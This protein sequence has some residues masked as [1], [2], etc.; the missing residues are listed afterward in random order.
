MSFINFKIQILLIVGML[1]I[2]S[3]T[4]LGKGSR[5]LG[6]SSFILESP[7]QAYQTE[8]TRVETGFSYFSSATY[9]LY[10]QNSPLDSRLMRADNLNIGFGYQFSGF[11]RANDLPLVIGIKAQGLSG[12]GSNSFEYPVTA[13]TSAAAGSASSTDT[14]TTTVAAAEINGYS[15]KKSDT[16][17][18]PSLTYI[19]FDSIAIGLAANSHSVI[20]TSSSYSTATHSVSVA[21]FGVVYFNDII[22]TGVSYRGANKGL[23]ANGMTNV[24]EPGALTL[25]N[26][27]F[28]SANVIGGFALEMTSN[29]AGD[30][31]EKNGLSASISAE[32]QI[33]LLHLEEKFT[34]L[35]AFHENNGDMLAR[36]VGGFQF[37]TS[38]DY[39]V[40][41]GLSVGGGFSYMRAA[42]SYGLGS[43]SRQLSNI[44]F[45]GG[46]DF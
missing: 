42:D 17:F 41:N 18:I 36:N 11:L 1:S 37:D 15:Y 25:S 13:S 46:Y 24:F 8:G 27:L 38:G 4:A 33:S 26:R 2:P 43:A 44:F 16:K 6:L 21:E 20:T 39:N 22:E 19:L 10:N 35:Q 28:M 9:E 23:S 14:T 3:A 45:R 34:F 30:D 5:K 40:A 29:P 12:T 7:A 32:I 31:G